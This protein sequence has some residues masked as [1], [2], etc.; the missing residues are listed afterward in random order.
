VER[1]VRQQLKALLEAAAAQQ[2]E[3]STSRQRSER[4]RAGAP[5][6][7]GPNPG[8]GS[9]GKGAVEPLRQRSRAESGPTATHGTPL[10]LANGPRASTATT[11]T[12]RATTTIEDA[13]D[14]T[15]ATTTATAASRRT[16]EVHGPLV[17]A[18]GMRGSPLVFA[19]QPTYLGSRTTDSPATPGEQRTT[20][21][22]SRTYRSTSAPR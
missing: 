3:S 19:L 16:R 5:F 13:G 20:S 15:T 2:V 6:A 17:R 18:S 9:E 10:R 12:A 1:R 7:H 21:S 22:S 4:G 11:T 14:A 8:I